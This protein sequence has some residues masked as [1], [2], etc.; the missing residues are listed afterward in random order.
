MADKEYKTDFVIVKSE[1]INDFVETCKG[2][3]GR[4]Y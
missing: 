3:R 2:L 1:S 4:G